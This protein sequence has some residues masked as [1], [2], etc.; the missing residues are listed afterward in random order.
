MD[1]GPYRDGLPSFG[2][3]AESDSRPL[4]LEP[5]RYDEHV[6]LI[7]GS[8]RTEK[9]R[10][11]RDDAR[12]WANRGP[13]D[14]PVARATELDVRLVKKSARA[15]EEDE[16]CGVDVGERHPNAM[17]ETRRRRQKLLPQRGG[18]G[19]EQTLLGLGVSTHVHADT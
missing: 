11:G 14:V 2:H 19:S 17:S 13:G 18:H 4:V 5:T 8:K 3:D 10:F 15:G 9:V 12:C 1:D 16:P 6:C 7:A